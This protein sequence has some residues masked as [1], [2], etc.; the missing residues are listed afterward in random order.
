MSYYSPST[1]GWNSEHNRSSSTNPSMGLDHSN[2]A[3]DLSHQENGG[4]AER[5]SL[6]NMPR[7]PLNAPVDTEEDSDDEDENGDNNNEENNEDG[8]D[9][10]EEEGEENGEDGDGNN[11][12]TIGNLRK[13]QNEAE[14][15]QES[16]S[17]ENA[18]EVVAGK[19]FKLGTYTLYSLS[20]KFMYELWCLPILYLW[21]HAF[22]K[23]VGFSKNFCAF[24]DPNKPEEVRE[25][26]L[27]NKDKDSFPWMLNCF[28]LSMVVIL[29]LVLVA[30]ICYI[31]VKYHS[32]SLIQKAKLMPGVAIELIK[33]GP[34]EAFQYAL[35][36]IL[37][38]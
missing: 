5:F 24:V 36:S 27:K 16:E 15:N 31:I 30:I 38:E 3:I 17:K 14:Q 2:A 9:G 13:A 10:D 19:T 33:G 28:L 20:W 6:Y 37:G 34:E 22:M 21:F 32:M 23:Y 18:A 8:E 4:D 35:E 11:M 26:I 12:S 7:P 1:K 29:V 25:M